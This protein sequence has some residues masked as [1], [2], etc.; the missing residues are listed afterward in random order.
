M[1]LRSR[2]LSGLEVGTSYR[3][4]ID[5]FYE[6]QLIIVDYYPVLNPSSLVLGYNLNA[7]SYGNMATTVQV[8]THL[9]P[10]YINFTSPIFSQS[11]ASLSSFEWTYLSTN[12][13]THTTTFLFYTSVDNNGSNI[14]NNNF[15][16]SGLWKLVG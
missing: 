8:A 15:T 9:I 10:P 5:D 12:I 2:A 16:I 3:M 1:L 4:A 11:S 7:F 13:L 6:N 14:V